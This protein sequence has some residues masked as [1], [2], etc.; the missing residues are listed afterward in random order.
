LPTPSFYSPLGGLLSR[1]ITPFFTDYIF[2][3]ILKFI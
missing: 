2:Y 1:V 3:P